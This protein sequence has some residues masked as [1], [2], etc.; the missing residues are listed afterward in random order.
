MN[1]NKWPSLQLT[2]PDNLAGVTVVGNTASV[3]KSTMPKSVFE[4]RDLYKKQRDEAWIEV[5][6][7]HE[8]IT[9]LKSMLAHFPAA[10]H[11]SDAYPKP[12]MPLRGE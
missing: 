10:P 8:E 7:C 12:A 4:E 1:D 5:A 11:D 3:V 6:Q 9:K 2:G